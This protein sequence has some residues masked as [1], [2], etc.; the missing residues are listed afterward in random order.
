VNETPVTNLI[1]P[2]QSSGASVHECCCPDAIAKPLLRQSMTG[3][4][5]GERFLRGCTMVVAPR[6]R[7][8]SRVILEITF[9]DPQGVCRDVR[10]RAQ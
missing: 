5:S 10:E 3:N 8:H 9:C 6:Q 4:A 7:K 2:L 1:N